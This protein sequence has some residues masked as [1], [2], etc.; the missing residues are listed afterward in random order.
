VI[1]VEISGVKI[2][3]KY[4]QAEK[5]QITEDLT[6][7]NPQYE[8]VTRFGGMRARFTKVPK[9]LE[10]YKDEY[11]ALI[12]PRG[13]TPP[14]P[15]EVI[16]DTTFANDPVSYPKLHIQLRDTQKS[17]AD[18]YIQALQSPRTSGV[19]VLP[20]G[21]GKSV[22]GI[23]LARKLKQ[24]ALI[25]VHKDDLVTGWTKDAKV[26]LGL[27]PKQVGI[28]KAGDFRIGQQITITTI[29]T[30][31]RLD[32]T[33][34]AFIRSQF[35]MII[36]DHSA[37]K[38]YELVTYFPARYRI[39]LSATPTRN[40]G[41]TKAL[42]LYFGGV[43]YEYQDEGGDEDIL[44]VTVKI[45]NCL[46]E[47]EIER[48]TFIERKKN[49]KTGQVTQVEKQK[50]INIHQVREATCYDEVFMEMLCCDVYEEYRYGKSCIVFSHERDHLTV[51]YNRMVKKGFDP[52]KLQVY[53]GGENKA[54]AI[55]RAESKEVLVTLATFHIA[56]EGTN[57]KAWE[58]GFL[59]SSVANANDTVQSIGRVRRRK[60]GKSDCVIYDY[61]FPR[62]PKAQDHGRIRDKVYIE[63]NFTVD[64]KEERKKNT[65]KTGR[66][67]GM[68]R[69]R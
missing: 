34:L 6:L 41:L 20:T 26:V 12:V 67:F 16:E 21:K 66:G 8:S 30:L 50:P 33:Q 7:P 43:A 62:V 37:S 32:R 51:L 47:P 36:V 48:E 61:R 31:S 52:S 64:G 54:E 49:K 44:P 35:G 25:V 53:V 28:I 9:F 39:G 42:H 58:R 60:A 23:Y 59:A 68:F 27:R 4:T 1:K 45:R 19:I 57:V 10:Y 17:A 40:D 11:G 5:E 55:K 15:C 46:I 63:R 14:F 56:T 29:Q 3:R 65:R 2:L 22:L 38:I 69:K 13:Y 18:A 24:K